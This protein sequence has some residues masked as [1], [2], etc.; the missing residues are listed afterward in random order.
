MK[1]EAMKKFLLNPFHSNPNM[2][3]TVA[4]SCMQK[5]STTSKYGHDGSMHDAVRILCST[6]HNQ[7]HKTLSC[8]EDSLCV[9]SSVCSALNFKH[10]QSVLI[11]FHTL[12]SFVVVKHRMVSV[13]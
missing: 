4:C 11:V 9:L 8:N 1:I 7:Y 2:C 13:H 6:D 3:R 10:I 12:Q 5:S